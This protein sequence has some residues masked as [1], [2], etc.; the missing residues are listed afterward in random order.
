MK[1]LRDYKNTFSCKSVILKTL[2]GEGISHLEAI[3]DPSCYSDLPT[4]LLTI[5]KKMASRLPVSMPAVLDPG[6]TGDNFTDR[7]RYDWNYPNFRDRMIGYAETIEAAHAETDRSRSVALWREIFGDDFKS[8]TII[9][10]S[11]A[12][13]LRS[14]EPWSGEKFIDQPPFSFPIRLNPRSHIKVEGRVTGLRV[15]Q[16]N[17]T[18]GFRQFTLSTHGNRVPKNRNMNF[19]VHIKNIPSPYRIYWKVRNGGVEANNAQCLRGEITLDA[20][21]GRK[22]EPTAYAG[23]HYVEAYVVVNDVV[24]AMD[25]QDVIVT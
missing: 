5:T 2:L 15:G 4:A 6:G 13:S 8:E 23:Y 3:E 14:S 1:Y 20:G 7:Y 18:N 19:S 11:A 17:R 25:R 9:K 22:V 10:K 24:V 21:Q 12:M 16:Y